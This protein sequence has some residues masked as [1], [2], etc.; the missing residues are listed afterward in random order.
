MSG[1]PPGDGTC[2]EDW[3][4]GGVGGTPGW[5]VEGD[6]W[7]PICEVAGDWSVSTRWS[8]MAEILLQSW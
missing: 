1:G 8:D 6:G 4:M 2:E 5:E 7:R 3:E